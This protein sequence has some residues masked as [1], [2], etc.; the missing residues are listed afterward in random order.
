MNS[1]TQQLCAFLFCY[2]FQL[3]L[4]M[5]QSSTNGKLNLG[6]AWEDGLEIKTEWIKL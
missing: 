5:E 2:V 4:H 1:V 6:K 3:R